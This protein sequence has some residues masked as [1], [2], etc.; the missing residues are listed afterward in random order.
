MVDS[1]EDVE[2]AVP[3]EPESRLVPP[4]IERDESWVTNELESANRTARGHEAENH[5]SP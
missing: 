5:L 2:E 3:N 1:V 4:R